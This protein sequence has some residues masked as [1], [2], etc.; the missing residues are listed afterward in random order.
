VLADSKKQEI[1]VAAKLEHTRESLLTAERALL[2]REAESN[3]QV[4][5]QIKFDKEI[6]RLKRDLEK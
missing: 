4:K 1:S 5:E 6:E 2:K 3:Q